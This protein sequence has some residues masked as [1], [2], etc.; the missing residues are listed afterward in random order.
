MVFLAR[1]G[2]TP[3]EPHYN[4]KKDTPLVNKVNRD[5]ATASAL[6]SLD[7]EWTQNG[8]VLRPV[9]RIFPLEIQSSET[10]VT[11]DREVGEEPG[12]VRTSDVK[13]SDVIF[14][15]FTSSGSEADGYQLVIWEELTSAEM[16]ADKLEA[17]VNLRR[18][19]PNGPKR[20]VKASE[21]LNV[22]RQ[23]S[24]RKPERFPKR[25]YS[26]EVPVERS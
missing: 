25:E 24:S 3:K 10:C 19:L 16:L 17:F 20:H 15:R 14:K 6:V 13:T 2:F 7:S 12:P 4:V 5:L 1:S 23:V 21:S 9:Q 22:G 11:E 26:H 8:T 18:S